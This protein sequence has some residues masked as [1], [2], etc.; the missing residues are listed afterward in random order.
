MKHYLRPSADFRGLF[1]WNKMKKKIIC[2]IYKITSPSGRVY[3][4]ETVDVEDRWKEYRRLDC[5]A[6]RKLYNSFLK[7]GT[8]AHIF[9]IVEECL[10]EDLLCRERHYQDFYDVLNGGLN[11]KLSSCGDSKSV[12]S[13]E[14]RKKIGDAQRGELNHMYGKVGEL[15]PMFGVPMSE[16]NRN[17]LRKK[18][19]YK[20][21]HPNSKLVMNTQTGIFYNT[22]KEAAEAHNLVFSSLR[23]ML[24]ENSKLVNKSFLIIC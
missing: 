3:I 14:T 10:F 18:K 16:E 5:K 8:D 4:G 17:K 22:I 11:L 21:G 23:S 15:N 19:T 24:N 7:Y 12:H 9:E 13:E 2:G 1:I 6:Q 20:T